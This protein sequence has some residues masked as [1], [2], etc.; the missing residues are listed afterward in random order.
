[1]RVADELDIKDYDLAMSVLREKY[2]DFS[3]AAAIYNQSSQGHYTNMFVMKREVFEAYSE[4]LFSILF[5]LEAHIDLRGRSKQQRRV[6]GH[7]SERLLGIY[8]T[9]MRI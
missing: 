8:F 5:E 6:F 2:P 4:W 1:Y 7:I 3:H 9:K